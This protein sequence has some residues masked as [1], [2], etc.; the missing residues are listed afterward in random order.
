MHYAIYLGLLLS[1]AIFLY[2]SGVPHMSYL[3]LNG[4]GEFVEKDFATILS[5]EPDVAIV[6]IEG[7]LH[8]AAVERLEEQLEE[9]LRTRIPVLILRLR[10]AQLLAS[11]AMTALEEIIGEAEERG[12]T[13]LLCGTSEHARAILRTAGLEAA[14]GPSRIFPAKP[15]VFESNS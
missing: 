12:V 2:E 8:F 6:D 14:M 10:G 13:I 7:P 5:E 9:I 11:S 4:M 3:T 1:I 15:V